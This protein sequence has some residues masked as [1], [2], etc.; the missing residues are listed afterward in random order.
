VVVGNVGLIF[1]RFN[2]VGICISG[3]YSIGQVNRCVIYKCGFSWP[4]RIIFIYLS[5]DISERKQTPRFVFLVLAP[6]SVMNK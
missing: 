4:H 6:L 1:D 2:V 3:S 5:Y